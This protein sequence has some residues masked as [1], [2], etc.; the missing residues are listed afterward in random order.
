MIIFQGFFFW[1]ISDD[2]GL[3]IRTEPGVH[4]EVTKACLAFAKW[5]GINYEFPIR[6]PVYLKKDYQI[7][8][9]FSKEMVS[10]TFFAPYDYTDEPYIRVATGDY[11]E[12]LE[13]NGRDH[14]LIAIL[15]SLGHELGH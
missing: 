11:L 14:A 3:R 6:V 2:L 5:L 7:T 15:S 1:A 4:A 8:N 9:K 10:A 13:K 12:L